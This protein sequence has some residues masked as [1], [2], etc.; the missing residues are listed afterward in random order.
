MADKVLEVSEDAVE[1]LLAL[2][3]AEEILVWEAQSV[4]LGHIFDHVEYIFD[5]LW[6]RALDEGVVGVP[7]VRDFVAL[8]VHSDDSPVGDGGRCLQTVDQL[9]EALLDDRRFALG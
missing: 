5:E 7:F 1:R 9:T 4:G 2:V 3:L 6:L 8:F